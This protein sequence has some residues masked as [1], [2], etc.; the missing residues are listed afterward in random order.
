MTASY[1][2]GW[3]TTVDNYARFGVVGRGDGVADSDVRLCATSFAGA[4]TDDNEI[5]PNIG[6][7]LVDYD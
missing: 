1:T 5:L 7:S 2:T 4:Q 3:D 6:T